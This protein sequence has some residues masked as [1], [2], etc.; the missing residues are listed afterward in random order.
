MSEMN[1]YG[2]IKK[3][4]NVGGLW[5]FMQMSYAGIYN[6]YVD[7]FNDR[8]GSW[9][10]QWDDIHS[11][12]NLNEDSD[13]MDQYNRFIR[14]RAQHIVDEINERYGFAKHGYEAAIDDSTILYMR[15]TDD[16]NAR[17][18]FEFKVE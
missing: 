4:G 14:E 13:L 16:H 6:Q 12:A 5:P 11:G 15:R 3:T 2:R 9:N 17:L 1:V 8:I 10:D 7:E 18:G